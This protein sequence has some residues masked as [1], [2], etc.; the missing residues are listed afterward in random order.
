[1]KTNYVLID[2]E[3]V[4]PKSI[5]ILDQ[6]HFKL[7]IFI[8]ATQ[9]KI[10]LA[11]ATAVQ[12]MG[13]RADYITIPKTGNNAL[14]FHI[15]WYLGR[16]TITDP[17]AYFHIISKDTG[18]DPLIQHLREHKI[19]VARSHDLVDMPLI[20][21]LTA[22]TL[23]E[24]VE[25]VRTNLE[26]RGVSKPRTVKTLTNTIKTLFQ[27]RLTDAELA[28]LLHELERQQVISIHDIKV[29]YG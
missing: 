7:L 12:K 24:Q 19:S 21:A 4:Q 17:T 29:T 16:L 22:T 9:T 1:M 26:Q 28:V 11:I 18:F 10:A 8:G 27:Q 20:K 3:N 2:Y 23:A 25:V 14:D 15:A 13:T 5:A 6:D